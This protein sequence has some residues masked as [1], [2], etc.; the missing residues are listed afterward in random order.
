MILSNVAEQRSTLR[1]CKWTSSIF[2]AFPPSPGMQ[3]FQSSVEIANR[4]PVRCIWIIP[5]LGLGKKR[6]LEPLAEI[7]KEKKKSS[8]VR[9]MRCSM[10]EAK[11]VSSCEASTTAAVASHWIFQSTVAPESYVH[12][13]VLF[14]LSNQVIL[15]SHTPKPVSYL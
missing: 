13:V 11:G 8:L 3:P 10:R 6:I 15:L 9:G 4:W 12:A 7:R 5:S 2:T 1:Y 14:L